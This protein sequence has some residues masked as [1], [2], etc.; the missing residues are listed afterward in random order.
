MIQVSKHIDLFWRKNT[1]GKI[2]K[3]H[4]FYI[5]IGRAFNLNKPEEKHNLQVVAKLQVYLVGL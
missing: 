3:I 4:I 1:H 2:T 5:D